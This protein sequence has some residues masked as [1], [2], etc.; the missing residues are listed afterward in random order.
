MD[1]EETFKIVKKSDKRQ[2][3]KEA[4]IK[5]NPPWSKH[6]ALKAERKVP[7]RNQLL[8]Y[9]NKLKE[10]GRLDYSACFAVLWLTGSRIG[11]IVSSAR[12]K[13]EPLEINENDPDTYTKGK[14]KADG[15]YKLL[16]K[17]NVIKDGTM[18]R[19]LR[20]GDIKIVEFEG[21]DCLFITSD[22]LKNPEKWLKKH[23]NYRF[24]ELP[25][26]LDDEEAKPFMDILSDYLESKEIDVQEPGNE[27]KLIF[28][29]KN[30]TFRTFLRNNNFP[31]QAF[32]II[33][34]SRTSDLDYQGLSS[35]EL[36][37]FFKWR[38]GSNMPNRYSHATSRSVFK[39]LYKK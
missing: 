2:L 9:C 22:V 23:P 12:Q 27:D 37:E 29:F 17:Y 24:K 30:R 36:K 8:E 13:Y 10:L 16:R 38:E 35:A 4:N 25:I 7:T 28:T 11:E 19:G 34:H 26:P 39:K 1:I 14:E 20:K 31:I 15:S 33:R 3:I 32:H 5:N 6:E 18:T 21:V